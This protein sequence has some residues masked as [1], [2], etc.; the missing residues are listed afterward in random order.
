M[1]HEV[2]TPEDFDKLEALR[3]HLLLN[4]KEFAALFGASRVTYHNWGKKGLRR[5]QRV[6]PVKRTI[7]KL[8]YLVQELNWP[9]PE[10][11][12]WPQAKRLEKVQH[13]L[14]MTTLQEG[15]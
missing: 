5:K 1:T 12:S 11:R 13:L 3:K 7:R 15:G 8:L 10:V 14:D 4:K 6:K 9:A 2:M